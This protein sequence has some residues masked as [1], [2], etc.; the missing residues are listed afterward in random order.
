MTEAKRDNNYIPTMIGTLQT[1]GVTPALVKADP[2][3][4]IIDSVVADTGSEADART[5]ATRDNNYIP[6]IMA[7]S[8]ADGLTPIPI[9]VDASGNLLLKST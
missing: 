8:S 6:T 7:V 4:N 9:Y 3:T 1:D 2:T 5:T